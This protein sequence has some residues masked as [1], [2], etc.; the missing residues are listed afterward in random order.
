MLDLNK[1]QSRVRRL[2]CLLD[3]FFLVLFHSLRG[4]IRSHDVSAFV[5]HFAPQFR[6]GFEGSSVEQMLLKT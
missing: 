3:F 4:V 2:E 5:P 6:P 1:E